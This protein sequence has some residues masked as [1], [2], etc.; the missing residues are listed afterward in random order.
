MKAL[1]RTGYVL[2]AEELDARY[3]LA[4]QSVPKGDVRIALD[5]P[6]AAPRQEIP[7]RVTA[8]ERLTPDIV[9]LCIQLDRPIELLPIPIEELA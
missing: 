4:C 8:Q 9:R 2:T 1:T 5:A 7:G 3:I 6:A